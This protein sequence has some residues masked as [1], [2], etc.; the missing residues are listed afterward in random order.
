MAC[1]NFRETSPGSGFHEEISFEECRLSEAFTLPPAE[2]PNPHAAP[3]EE[4]P[5]ARH[6]RAELIAVSPLLYPTESPDEVF[7]RIMTLGAFGAYRET[8]PGSDLYEYVPRGEF[9]QGAGLLESRPFTLPSPES[10]LPLITAARPREEITR[11]QLITAHRAYPNENDDEVIARVMA[12]GVYREMEPDSG[13]YEIVSREEFLQHYRDLEQL[14]DDDPRMTRYTREDL[15]VPIQG[16]E[17]LSS[18]EAFA[19]VMASG[20]Y[21]E[22]EMGSGLYEKVSWEEFLEFSRRRRLAQ[23]NNAGAESGEMDW[24]VQ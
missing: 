21:R 14:I 20:N 12:F 24:N 5:R 23:S 8:E 4:R 6:T 11:A 10:P 13:L 3:A 18:D 15:I 22:T 7:A 17:F 16:R 9:L 1:N 2:R 19:R